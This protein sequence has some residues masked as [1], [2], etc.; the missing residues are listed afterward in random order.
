M[1]KYLILTILT[2]MPLQVFAGWTSSIKVNEI[3][4][5][6]N[7]EGSS[8]III[9][10]TPIGVEPEIGTCNGTYHYLNAATAKGN[11][12]FSILMAAKTTDKPV[13]LTLTQGGSETRCTISG[14]R[15]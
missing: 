7:E 9:F 6:G 3:I 1:K 2:M 10:S 15:Y 13:R 12:M 5:E 14:I 8:L 11:M 4:A